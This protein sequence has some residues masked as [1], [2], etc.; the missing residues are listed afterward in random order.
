V[1]RVFEMKGIIYSDNKVQIKGLMKTY[2]LKWV[3]SQFNAIWKSDDE[4]IKAE[5]Q[6]DNG[7]TTHA[8]L[9]YWGPGDTEF[10]DQFTKYLLHLGAE[11]HDED[12]NQQNADIEKLIDA[13]MK[14]WD[15]VHKP[16]VEAMRKPSHVGIHHGAP[17]SFIE[18]ALRDYEKK[19]LIKV[20]EVREQ[21]MKDHGLTDK[22]EDKKEAT[23]EEKEQMSIDDILAL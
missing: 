8:T 9:T 2:G 14:T 1:K 11:G 17:E 15:L 23:K 6:R 12:H 5:F 20:Q 22:K 16:N 18:A 10:I 3:G 21:V 7:V 4:T 13:E 19:R